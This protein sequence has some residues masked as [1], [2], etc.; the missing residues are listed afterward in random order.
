MGAMLNRVNLTFSVNVFASKL[1]YS[2]MK[3]RSGKVSKIFFKK[4]ST[5]TQ[6]SSSRVVNLSE[7]TQILY[8]IMHTLLTV[9]EN[10]CNI[11]LLIIA[12]STTICSL[13]NRTYSNIMPTLGNMRQTLPTFCPTPQ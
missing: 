2:T 12:S 8:N 4:Y 3:I 13:L 10:L 7:T 6:A 5:A 11:M 9:L 1:Q